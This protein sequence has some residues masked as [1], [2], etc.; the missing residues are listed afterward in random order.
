MNHPVGRRLAVIILVVAVTVGVFTPHRASAIEA[1]TLPAQGGAAETKSRERGFVA[2]VPSFG[3]VIE[4]II[5][6][7]GDSRTNCVLDLDAGEFIVAPPEVDD[8]LRNR[9]DEVTKSTRP[10]EPILRW[11]QSSGADL[12]LAMTSPDVA[13]TLYEGLISPAG[14]F[15]A[16]SPSEVLSMATEASQQRGADD[17]PIPPMWMFQRLEPPH[18]DDAFVFQ[19]REGGIGLLQIVGSTEQPRSV[20]IRYKLV[21]AG[22][23]VAS[24]TTTASEDQAEE[25]AIDAKAATVTH[26]FAL[27]N[28][29]AATMA[30]ELKQQILPGH[31]GKGIASAVDNRE[32]T[33]TAPPDE[34]IRVQTLITVTDWPDAIERGPDHQ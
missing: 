12:T 9:F 33:V 5:V 26:T 34:M 18:G 7:P 8:L 20:K 10:V 4:R 31:A 6:H 24:S 28:V 29:S 21:V 3:P 22:T 19:T 11:A 23:S 30:E 2:E 15:D 14:S 27:R 16:T 32:V 25:A 1:G 17:K 13:L